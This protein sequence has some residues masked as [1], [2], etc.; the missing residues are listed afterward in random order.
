MYVRPVGSNTWTVGKLAATTDALQL[1]TNRYE[2]AEIFI[3]NDPDNLVDILW[4]NSTSQL[5]QLSP[6]DSITL[7][8][9]NV[10]QVYVKTV[11]STATVPYAAFKY[12]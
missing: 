1:S 2:C 6:G 3:E 5:F 10:N 11:S 4:G 7:P 8:V 12:V 9:Q